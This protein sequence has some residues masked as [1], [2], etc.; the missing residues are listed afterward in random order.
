MKKVFQLLSLSWV[1]LLSAC[2]QP[3]ATSSN[4]NAPSPN[5]SP[6]T[7]VTIVTNDP[8]LDSSWAPEWNSLVAYWPLSGSPGVIADGSSVSANV[9][10][11]AI[12]HSDSLNPL[13]YTSSP[14]MYFSGANYL[15][16]GNP[17]SFA[18]GTAARTMCAWGKTESVTP[19]WAWMI[20]YGSPSSGNAMFIGLNSDTLD[21]GGYGDDLTVGNFW[22]IGSWNQICLTF[23]GAT[24]A[25]YANGAL[26][27]SASKNWNL[28]AENAYIGK[29]VNNGEY[30]TGWIAE[31]AVW[32]TAL[33]A[34]D[35][36]E[37]Y[38]RQILEF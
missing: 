6:T 17:T 19:Q 15:D 16:L 22:A 32:T 24:A 9:G 34:A 23:D 5:P 2:I 27:S 4:Q 3:G 11:P 14:G 18:V 13:A 12:A 30:W 33:T 1:I 31:V 20:A 7:P 38:T 36:Q 28:V 29:Q 25:L 8:T 10:S 26:V 37:I 21:G 35:V